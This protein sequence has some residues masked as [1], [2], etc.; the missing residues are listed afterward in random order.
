MRVAFFL[1]HLRGGGAERVMATLANALA[2][3]GVVP[4][5]VLAEA[6]GDLIKALRE[7]I[8]VV[9]LRA[10]RMFIALPRLTA[11]LKR[12][13]PDALI[14]TLSQPNIVAILAKHWARA[15][16]RVVVREANT[17]NLEFAH[18]TLLKDRIVPSLIKRFYPKV[19]AVVAVSRG[20]A[21]AL[22][23]LGVPNPIVIYNPVI[24]DELLSLSK[25]PVSHPWY[26]ASEP[27]VLG[28]GRLELQKDFATLIRAFE[29]VQRQRPANLVILGEGSQRPALQQ[30]VQALGIA[31]QVDMPGYEPNPFAYMRRSAVFVLSSKFEGLPNALI[32]AMACGCPVVSTD[33]PSGPAEILD[34][35]RYGHLV[36]VGD[37]DALASAILEV[38]DGKGKTVPPE[39]LQQF[40]ESQVVEQY[41][42]VLRGESAHE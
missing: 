2:Q 1:A 10:P 25:L 37:V 14:S 42:R 5:L 31:E 32:Q 28:V 39:W 30:L 8:P 16:T 6:E 35:G 11:Y 19:D 34:S 9:D 12:H 23:Q 22:Q 17:P 18:A 38:L 33:C 26:Q 36:P 29:R 4:T 7:E 27:V 3:R 40:E 21:H 41:W 24:T 13:A 20:V 15:P